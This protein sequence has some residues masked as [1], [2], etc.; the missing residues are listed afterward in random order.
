MAPNKANREKV[1][2]RPLHEAAGVKE[3]EPPRQVS[4]NPYK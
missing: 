3:E 4:V 1:T 2:D